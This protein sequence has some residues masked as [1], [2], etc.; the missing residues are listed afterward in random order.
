[1]DVVQLDQLHSEIWCVGATESQRDL[2]QSRRVT[3][4]CQLVEREVATRTRAKDLPPVLTKSAVK[5]IDGLAN[6]ELTS[7][8]TEPQIAAALRRLSRTMLCH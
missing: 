1:M 7:R 4:P 3:K 8:W 2:H 5:A 6:V